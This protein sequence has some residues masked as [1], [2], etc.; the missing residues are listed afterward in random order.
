MPI[1]QYSCP[2]CGHAF[3]ANVEVKRRHKV[4]CCHCGK[5]AEKTI[6]APSVLFKGEGWTP[7]HH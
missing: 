6:S 5:P 4:D 2:S 7:K 1:Y 3:E